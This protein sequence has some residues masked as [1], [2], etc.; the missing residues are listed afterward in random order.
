MYAFLIIYKKYNRF[1]AVFFTSFARDQYDLLTIYLI[2]MNNFYLLIF[3]IVFSNFSSIS[4]GW[5]TSV[6]L[7]L[8]E[9]VNSKSND[10]SPLFYTDST[11]L[12]FTRSAEEQ[13]YKGFFNQDIWMSKQERLGVWAEATPVKELNNHLNNS[14][15]GFSS[16]GDK[17]YLLDSY[18]KNKTSV[19]GIAVSEMKEGK[20]TEPKHFPIEGLLVEGDFCGFSIN[21]EENVIVMSY[22]GPLSLGEEDLYVSFK[23]EKDDWS[24][25]IHLGETINTEKFEISPFLTSDSDTLYFSTNGREGFG[26]ADIF[27]SVRLDDSWQ[28][29]SKPKN[30]GK[31]IN[32]PN[33]DA[34]LHIV[35][36]RIFWSSDREMIGNEDIYYVQKV[37]PPKLKVGV[38]E[39]KSISVFKGVDGKVTISVEGGVE[40]YTYK[41]SNGST[42]KDLVNVSDGEYTVIVTDAVDQEIT[43]KAIVSTPKLEVGE[44]IAVFFDPPVVLYYALAKTDL[45]EESKKSLER[46]ISVLNSNPDIKLEVGSYTD[47]SGDFTYNLELS[48]LRA[49][50][51]VEYLKS[52][53][54]NPNRIS[55]DGFGETKLVVKC[56]CDKDECTEEN[57][58]KNRRTEFVILK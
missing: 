54:V 26:G 13:K 25:P 4:Q 49:A 30:L 44:N 31:V 58:K 34:Y 3:S 32:S 53:I 36:N 8:K 56:N 6:P 14:V 1:C 51:T 37:K 45:T 41:W 11:T 38:K 9:Q 18:N 55:G 23:Q 28:N 42:E 17:V 5:I 43:L 29:W 7:K 27:F 47:C 40:P 24:V 39:S 22:K 50:K 48:K 21:K 20:W 46:V 33:F 2:I 57:H 16:K 10:V 35:G 52:R 19:D 12:Y 15:L